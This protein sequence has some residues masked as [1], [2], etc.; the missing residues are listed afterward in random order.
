MKFLI[1]YIILSTC[2]SFVC[3]SSSLT[4]TETF[5]LEKLKAPRYVAVDNHHVY[6]MEKGAILIY[7]MKDYSLTSSINI[8]GGEPTA[9][10]VQTHQLVATTWDVVY[11]F[12]KNGVLIKEFKTNRTIVHPLGGG[13][14]K[15]KWAGH[16][17][18]PRVSVLICD[19]EMNSLC[20]VHSQFIAGESARINAV[21]RPLSICTDSSLNHLVVDTAAGPIHVYDAD[22]K[23]KFTIDPTAKKI[24]I[25]GKRKK[26]I[27]NYFKTIYDEEQLKIILYLPKKFPPVYATFSANGKIYLLTYKRKKGN[28]EC[29][30]Y[31][32]N[33]LL[34]KKVY[35]PVAYRTP[36]DAF[37]MVINNDTSYQ[38]VGQKK[39]WELHIT[40]LI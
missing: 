30:I 34:V 23:K 17:Q 4:G 21:D 7:S 39:K 40:P 35:H 5:N 8:I 33:G 10:D 27:V 38:V 15:T 1:F 16:Q 20:Q 36:I 13:F 18:I 29:L 31:D 28:T 11:I 3:F 24:A 6:V 2:F 22:C 25:R 32:K 19:K 37:P 12:K 26:E 14:V 9:L